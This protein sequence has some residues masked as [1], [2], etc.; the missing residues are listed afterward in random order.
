MLDLLLGV[1]G[2]KPRLMA[3]K[4]TSSLG[5]RTRLGGVGMMPTDGV[6][7]VS[8]SYLPARVNTSIRGDRWQSVV[9]AAGSLCSVGKRR[10]RMVAQCGPSPGVRFPSGSHAPADMSSAK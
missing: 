2:Q 9:T 8:I 10:F 1:R 4:K 3:F 7:N 6:T 5:G